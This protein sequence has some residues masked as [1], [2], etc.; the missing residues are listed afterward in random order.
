MQGLM[1]TAFDASR[2]ARIAS[3]VHVSKHNSERSLESLA[4]MIRYCGA[5]VSVSDACIDI[6]MPHW[7]KGLAQKS[8]GF[9]WR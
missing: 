9:E 3:L 6:F 2:E 4:S 7:G 8:E 5:A 1:A